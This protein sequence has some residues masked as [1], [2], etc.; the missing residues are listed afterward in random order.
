M[1]AREVKAAET[2]HSSLS[3]IEVCVFIFGWRE[4]EAKYMVLVRKVSEE[5]A[6]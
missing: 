5:T 1:N 3:R 4:G 6:R 2:E